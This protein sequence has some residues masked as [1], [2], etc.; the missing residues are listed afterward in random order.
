MD[1]EAVGAATPEVGTEIK[2][3]GNVLRVRYSIGAYMRWDEPGRFGVVAQRTIGLAP[4]APQWPNVCT[5]TRLLDLMGYATTGSDGSTIVHVRNFVCWDE[6]KIASEDEV[7]VTAT[8]RSDDPVFLTHVVQVPPPVLPGPP[9]PPTEVDLQI[10]IFSW[11]G[12]G[13]PKPNVNFTWRA[14]LSVSLP[15]GEG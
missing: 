3:P 10:R 11:D 13:Q 4:P 15:S 12:S 2:F 8:A 6:W 7:W 1:Q 9:P 14:V 5:P